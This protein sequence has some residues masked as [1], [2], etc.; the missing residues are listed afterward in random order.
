MSLLRVTARSCLRPVVPLCPSFRIPA[1]VG[2]VSD[3]KPG[4]GG[5]RLWVVRVHRFHEIPYRIQSGRF[6]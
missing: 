4:S 1:V 6:K 2:I 5:E 3:R